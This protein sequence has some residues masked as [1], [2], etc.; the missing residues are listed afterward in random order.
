MT[1]VC[2]LCDA[3][4]KAIRDDRVAVPLISIDGQPTDGSVMLSPRVLEQLHQ[5]MKEPDDELPAD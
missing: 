1:K 4:F 3:G 5:L 2:A